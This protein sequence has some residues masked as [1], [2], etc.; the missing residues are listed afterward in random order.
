MVR[1]SWR[2]GTWAVTLAFLGVG[3]GGATK[4]VPVEGKVTLDGQPVAGAAVS[5]LM[6]P[7]T[8]QPAHGETQEDGSYR[9]NTANLGEGALPGEYKVTVV[10]EPP[11]PPQFRSGEGGPSRQEQQRA[12][13]QAQAKARKTGKGPNIPAI[14]SDPVKTPLKVKVPAP[15]GRADFALTSKGD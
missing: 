1:D 10:W 9:I 12:I 15:G 3:C 2:A 7:G 8:P 14:Y 11:P 6:G 13:E 5:F 4:P